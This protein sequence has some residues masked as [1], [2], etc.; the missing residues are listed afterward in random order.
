MEEFTA[1][2]FAEFDA[3]LDEQNWELV[4][5]EIVIPDV[6]ELADDDTEEARDELVELEANLAYCL[7]LVEWLR[8]GIYIPCKVLE[9]TFV[10]QLATEAPR[11][12]DSI[13]R[14][15]ALLASLKLLK[16]EDMMYT[17]EEFAAKYA[18]L[19]QMSGQTTVPAGIDILPVPLVCQE[20]THEAEADLVAFIADLEAALTFE[21]WLDGQTQTCCQELGIEYVALRKMKEDQLDTLYE[22]IDSLITDIELITDRTELT[23]RADFEAES[24]AGTVDEILDDTVVEDSPAECQGSTHDAR[25]D[26]VDTCAELNV[27]MTFEGWLAEQLDSACVAAAWTL[28]DIID[29]NTPRLGALDADKTALFATWAELKAEEGE[30]A[31][32]FEI[33]MSHNFNNAYNDESIE[34]HS[35]GLEIFAIPDSCRELTHIK[36]AEAQALSDDLDRYTTFC[37][38]LLANVLAACDEQREEI[39]AMLTDNEP[40]LPQS[41]TDQ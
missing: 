34:V 10:E 14:H 22:S 5:T 20:E 40:R 30:D 15:A 39:T 33:R 3:H 27:A 36:L 41:I 21:A 31:L 35:A 37:D 18:T 11:L 1:R 9:D 13:A 28:Q 6:P 24:E 29:T 19:F 4:S 26:V 8:E 12:D 7:T 23:L 25:Q 17:D 16:D 38:W 32:A 2:M